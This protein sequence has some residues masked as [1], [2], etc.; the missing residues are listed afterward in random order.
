MFWVGWGWGTAGGGEGVVAVFTFL[1]VFFF[2]FLFVCLFVVC[3]VVLFSPGGGGREGRSG[4][5]FSSHFPDV[6]LYIYFFLQELLPRPFKST[7]Q[8]LCLSY[9][10]L[11][12]CCGCAVYAVKHAWEAKPQKRD[13]GV[14]T[15]AAKEA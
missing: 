15:A 2:G 8:L 6:F 14:L 1:F 12:R 3:F 7:T 5:L 13:N 10:S 4:A 9:L 11:F